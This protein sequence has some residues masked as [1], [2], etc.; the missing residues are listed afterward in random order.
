MIKVAN[1]TASPLTVGGKHLMPGHSLFV[2]SLDVAGEYLQKSGS[3]SATSSPIPPSVPTPPPPTFIGQAHP[4]RPALI[5]EIPVIKPTIPQQPKSVPMY[6]DR[7]E[8]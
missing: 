6:R 2:E 7:K 8:R 5:P 1:L 3:I 4:I